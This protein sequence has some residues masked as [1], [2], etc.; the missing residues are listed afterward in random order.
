MVNLGHLGTI[1]TSKKPG[2]FDIKESL[3]IFVLNVLVVV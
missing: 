2:R 3:G 1:S